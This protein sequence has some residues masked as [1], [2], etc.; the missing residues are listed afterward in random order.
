MIDSH[1]HLN[2]VD[3]DAPISD[4]LK[5]AEQ[6]G[7]KACLAVACDSADFSELADQLKQFPNL[8]GAMGIHPEYADKPYDIKKLCALIKSTPRVVAVGECGLDY[9]EMPED[10]KDKQKELFKA[11]IDLAHELALPLVI[12]SRDAEGDMRSLLKEAY[13]KGKLSNGFVLHCFSGS[14][15][16]AK[17]TIKMGG[18]LSASGVLTFKNASRVREAFSEVPMDRLL[19]ETD[20]PYLA[21]EPYR[22]KKNQP[23]FVTNTLEKLAEIKG[24]SIKEMDEFTTRNF[25]R[26]FLKGEK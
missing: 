16:M 6:A 23:A 26:L 10:S 18:Y 14:V 15:D 22:G 19:I 8:F 17:E 25:Y 24:V 12:H 4:I 2:A 11:Q 3:Y 20:A 7:V 9:H 21:P 13:A 5:N 1:C